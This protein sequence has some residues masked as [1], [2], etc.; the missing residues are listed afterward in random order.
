MLLRTSLLALALAACSAPPAGDSGEGGAA[1]GHS[2]QP[3]VGAET[4]TEH[5]AVLAIAAVLRRGEALCTGTLIAPNLVLTAQHCIAPTDDEAVDCDTSVFAS[6]YAAAD[7]WV[8]PDTRL[9][10]SADFYPAREIHVPPDSEDLC[11]NDIALIVLDGQFSASVAP[12]APRFTTPVGAGEFYTAVG[13]GDALS[14]GDPGVR[15]MREGLQVGCGTAQCRAGNTLAVTE[16][17]G[18][19]SVCE[20]DSGGP[21]LDANERILGVVSRGEENCGRTIYSA[22]APW[23]SWIVGV[24]Q[25]AR[26]LGNYSTP[27]WLS[28]ASGSGV[29]AVDPGIVEPSVG[30]ID[31]P[32][33]SLPGG[34]QPSGAATSTK[35]SA[36]GCSAAPVNRVAPAWL[37]VAILAFAIG[38]A[39]ARRRR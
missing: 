34:D 11:G 21:A 38:A 18:D 8:S 1:V 30:A 22:V 27:S 35:S 29:A 2:E 33:A 39:S 28:E 26:G 36:G 25:R 15:R 6:T 3:I 12:M 17:L 9:D 23:Q 10:R 5:T 16:F 32:G 19:E 37:G 31:S 4:D 20:G 24:A 14:E 7:V 13:F